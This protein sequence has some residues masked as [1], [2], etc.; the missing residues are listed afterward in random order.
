ML[1]STCTHKLHYV[2]IISQIKAFPRKIQRQ[3]QLARE[4]T[5]VVKLVVL[6]FLH[7]LPLQLEFDCLGELLHILGARNLLDLKVM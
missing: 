5:L 4:P 6:Q 7:L 2:K 1:R 3:G